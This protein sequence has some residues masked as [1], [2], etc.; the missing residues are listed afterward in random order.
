MWR[1]NGKGL[2]PL[3]MTCTERKRE[4]E[5]RGEEVCRKDIYNEKKEREI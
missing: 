3:T 1:W 4:R 2:Y 5:K